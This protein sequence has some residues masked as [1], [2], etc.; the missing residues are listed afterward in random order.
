MLA[1]IK[2][3]NVCVRYDAWFFFR[4]K[5]HVNVPFVFWSLEL[6]WAYWSQKEILHWLPHSPY[7]HVDMFSAH[8][9]RYS[10]AATNTIYSLHISVNLFLTDFFIFINC[11]YLCL[12]VK[13]VVLHT[14]NR[15]RFTVAVDSFLKTGLFQISCPPLALTA[16]LPI[17]FLLDLIKTCTF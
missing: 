8:T 4:L 3:W 7:F 2:L 12:Q 11:P 9:K 1:N 13:S 15:A 14:L 16:F 5:L 10:R 6:E 17:I